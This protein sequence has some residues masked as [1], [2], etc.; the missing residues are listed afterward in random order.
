MTVIQAL[1][2]T[3]KYTMDNITID[4]L[5]GI[6]I[7]IDEGEFVAITGPS[8]SGKSTLLH[9]LGCVDQPTGGKVFINTTDTSTLT[10]RALTKLRLREVGFVFQQFHL[11]P[12]LTAFEN[13]EL[14]MKEAGMSKKKRKER[15]LYLLDLMG[16]NGRTQ[17]MPSQLS[18]GEKQRV[19]IARALANKPAI[20]LADEPTGE[21]D[22]AIGKR[23]LDIFHFINKEFGQTIVV[24]THDEH[25]SSRAH[26]IIRLKD[27][28]IVQ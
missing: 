18:G 25:V 14:P 23:I 26:R 19:A 8:G 28:R 6:N 16:L 12:T 2:I 15:T 13:V 20:V 27:G 22:S 5:Q 7:E 17:H 1:N 21:L 3:K 24:V 4:S 11:L 10:R 9:I